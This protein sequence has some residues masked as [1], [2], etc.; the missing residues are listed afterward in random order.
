MFYFAL[1][2]AFFVSGFSYPVIVAAATVLAVVSFVDDLRPVNVYLRMGLQL[3]AVGAACVEL[4]VAELLPWWGVVLA[5]IL[6]TGFVNA[7]NFMDGIN[8]I[9]G[10]YSLL[11][12]VTL[13]MVDRACLYADP[14]FLIIMA[15]GS[16]IFCICN[17]RRHALCFAGDVGAVTVG[18][19]MLVAV[20]FDMLACH[21]ITPAVFVAVYGVDSALT[22]LHRIWLRQNILRSHRM[23]LYQI[24]ANELRLG[25]IRT[26]AVYI[27]VQAAINAGALWLPVAPYAYLWAVVALLAVVYIVMMR[28]YFSLHEY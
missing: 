12:F 17:C 18:F 3:A 6:G 22:I 26:A 24:M 19:A 4:H 13:L 15:M 9:T 10:A 21:S 1:V 27:V 5:V 25:H 7:C 16:A 23:H 8:G 28:R 14:S 2:A 20:G 11:T